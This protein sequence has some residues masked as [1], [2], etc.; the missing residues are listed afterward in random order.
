MPYYF[1]AGMIDPKYVAR[2]KRHIKE[3]REPYFGSKS[4]ADTARLGKM[5][6]TATATA[7]DLYE[8]QDTKDCVTAMLQYGGVCS[9]VCIEESDETNY[10]WRDHFESRGVD[11]DDEEA[12]AEKLDGYDLDESELDDDIPRDRL[13]WI[14]PALAVQS[15]V[16]STLGRV[17]PILDSPFFIETRTDEPPPEADPELGHFFLAGGGPGMNYSG[18]HASSF[19]AVSLLYYCIEALGS[20]IE[21]EYADSYPEL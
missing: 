8:P 10:T 6:A 13:V 12:L 3:T 9:L 17:E 5:M 4:R 16:S 18:L 20:T 11:F 1:K 14:D 15:K 2:A 7:W 19:L 21:L